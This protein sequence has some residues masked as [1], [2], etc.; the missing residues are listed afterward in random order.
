MDALKVLNI[1]GSRPTVENRSIHKPTDLRPIA[2]ELLRQSRTARATLAGEYLARRCIGAAATFAFYHPRALTYDR[3]NKVALPALV[4]PLYGANGFTAVHRTFLA[5]D[6]R[7]AAIEEPKKMLGLP[8]DG[9]VRF[10]PAH[11]E[12]HL[13][14]GFEDAVSVRIM[15]QLPNCWAACGIERY[16]DIHIPPTVRRVVIWSQ[17]GAEAARA[18]ERAEP[19]LRAGGRDLQVELPP[20]GGDWNDALIAQRASE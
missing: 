2:L 18:I 16:A 7:K 13:A 1:T 11:H 10:G 17:H 12:L 15:K 3:G 6:A 9:A 4:L 14:E 20:P 8:L 5:A 19:H